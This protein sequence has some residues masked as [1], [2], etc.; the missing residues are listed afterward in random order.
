MKTDPNMNVNWLNNIL[1]VNR[2]ESSNDVCEIAAYWY[3]NHRLSNVY[4]TFVKHNLV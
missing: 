4:V 3:E 1:S 2:V